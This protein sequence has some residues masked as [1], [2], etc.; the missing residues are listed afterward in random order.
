MDVL[1]CRLQTYLVYI[2]VMIYTEELLISSYTM[3]YKLTSYIVC[4]K[5]CF[6]SYY[7]SM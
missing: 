6:R 4:I 7:H 5:Y 1:D 2:Y 3:I